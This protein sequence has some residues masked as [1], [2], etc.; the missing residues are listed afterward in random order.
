[1][2][3]GHP[4]FTGQ[5]TQEILTRHAYDPVPP[6]PVR[7]EA[8][9]LA[10]YRTVLRALAKQPAER[11][12]T[13]AEFG[14]AL[15]MTDRDLAVQGRAQAERHDGR[16]RTRYWVLG[17]AVMSA[18]VAGLIVIGNRRPPEIRLGHRP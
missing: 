7:F 15:A 14:T 16:I 12:A 2:L 3:A 18:V 11:F 9:N 10:I 13:A 8:E 6:L 17:A 1:M 4:P 5:S